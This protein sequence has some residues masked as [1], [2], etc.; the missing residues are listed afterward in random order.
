MDPTDPLDAI[1]DGDEYAIPVEWEE[2]NLKTGETKK[3]TSTLR[4]PRRIELEELDR[5]DNEADI[6]KYGVPT[7]KR[8]YFYCSIFDIETEEKL[9][10]DAAMREQR[11]VEHIRDW[12]ETHREISLRDVQETLLRS[13]VLTNIVAI[14]KGSSDK[15]LGG[16]KYIY[17]NKRA[18]CEYTYAV[19]FADVGLLRRYF[20][21][22]EMS[23]MTE[24]LERLEKAGHVLTE[25]KRPEEE[26]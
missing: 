6:E 8:V 23:S 17:N 7:Y 11:I 26:V 5:K 16:N 19:V 22:E 3:R 25:E 10:G 2:R 9:R 1:L 13:D 20:A 14:R 4:V 24:N 18:L 21:A 15:A 12:L